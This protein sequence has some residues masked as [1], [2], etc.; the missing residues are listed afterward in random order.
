MQVEGSGEPK[1]RSDSYGC[2]LRGQ[3][4]EVLATELRIPQ[5]KTMLLLIWHQTP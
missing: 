4:D 2:I 5:P 1:P 3:G